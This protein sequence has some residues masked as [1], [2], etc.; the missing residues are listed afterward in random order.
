MVADR[1]YDLSLHRPD[2]AVIA[3]TSAT[4]VTCP[5][6]QEDARFAFAFGSCTR[7]RFDPIQPGWASI[8]RL[9]FD[10]DRDLPTRRASLE[11]TP[12]RF[13]MHL[14][15]TFYFYDSDVLSEDN[16]GDLTAVGDAHAAARAAHLSSRLNPHFLDMARR[17][18]SIAV[19]D[20]HDFRGNNGDRVDFADAPAIRDIF[21][22]YWGNP[23]V[24]APWRSFGL[25]TRL[26]Y[27][28][29][30]IYLMDGRFRRIKTG[31]ERACF[32][33]A[34][35]ELVLGDIADRSR[36][37]GGRM[38]ILASGSPW[39]GMDNR[40]NEAFAGYPKE[41][42]V[43]FDGLRALMERDLIQGLAFLSGDIHR[44]EVYEVQ[45]GGGRVA[46]E[47]ICSPIC[48][49]RSDKESRS[50]EGERCFS[51]GVDADDGLY[52]GF[53]SVSID[54]TGPAG[55]KP[56]L[57]VT[58]RRSDNGAIFFTHNYALNNNEFRF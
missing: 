30:D 43:L 56:R 42:T 57:N 3:G 20:D 49:P 1:A 12:I 47:F 15:D 18:P 40:V 24:P 17:L 52:A 4:V 34:Q 37:L 16:A 45:I 31:S 48:K 6:E 28:K 13:F 39:N 41:R 10:V 46:P 19:W 44:H 36:R 53:A 5:P 21:L 51:R 55:R 23:S 27:G 8:A 29:T 9:A 54:T 25:A 26:T 35:C 32:T 33:T 38:V 50:L 11:E 58:Y 7:N 14:G 2:G 22:D